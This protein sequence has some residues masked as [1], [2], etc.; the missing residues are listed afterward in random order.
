MNRGDC[1]YI[2]SFY[3]YQVH[4]KAQIQP[5]KGER[6]PASVMLSIQY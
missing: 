1:L 6:K 4:G 3:F 2:P 5:L